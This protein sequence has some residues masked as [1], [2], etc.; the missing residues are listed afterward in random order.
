MLSLTMDLFLYVKGWIVVSLLHS[1]QAQDLVESTQKQSQSFEFETV[2]VIPSTGHLNQ[3]GPDGVPEEQA[4]VDKGKHETLMELVNKKES[5]WKKGVE[6]YMESKIQEE[7]LLDLV[8]QTQPQDQSQI[9]GAD[10][11]VVVEEK[12][13]KHDKELVNN[14][15][16]AEAAVYNS[17]EVEGDPSINSNREDIT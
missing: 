15:G 4:A 16:V 2:G 7:E 5:E 10:A 8:R 14:E 3:D 11:V 12:Q 13:N 1:F 6:V 17:K 9:L